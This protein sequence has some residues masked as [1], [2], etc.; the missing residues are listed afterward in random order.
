MVESLNWQTLEQRRWEGR[1]V[2]FY[3]AVHGLAAIPINNYLTQTASRYRTR[4]SQQHQ[5]MYSIPFSRT[6]TYRFSF[7]GNTVR[8]WNSLPSELV[9]SPSASS[10][11]NGL[12]RAQL[13]Q[14]TD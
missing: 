12:V 6:D 7:F 10:F 3:K 1:L 8:T 13:Y 4:Y 2:L 5:L 14:S 9:K 11:R